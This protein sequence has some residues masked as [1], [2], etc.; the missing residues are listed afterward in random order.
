MTKKR[1]NTAALDYH[2]SYPPGKLEIRA[3]KPLATRHDLSLAYSPGVADACMAI[4]DNQDEASAVTA[5]SNLVAVISNGTAVLGLGNIG[6]LASKPVMEGKAVLFKHFGGINV[7]DIEVNETEVDKFCDVVAALE[8]TFGG[9]NLEDIKAPECFEIER[10]LK[11][12]LKIP[13]FHD[14]QHGTA[15]TASA[16]LINGL[17]LTNKTAETIRVVCNGAGAAGIACLDMFIS[18]GV[19][20]E[21]IV[22]CDSKGVVHAGRD[23]LNK[24]K[25]EFAVETT[26]RTLADAMAGSDVFLGVSGPGLVTQDMVK[27]MAEKPLIFAMANP[28]P[29]ILPEE[30]QAARS[31][32]ICATGRS[33]FANQINNVLCFP[34]LFRG[35]LDVGAQIIN[36]EM[37]IACAHAIANLARREIDDVVQQAYVGENLQFGENMILPKPFDQRLLVEVPT[38]VAEAAMKSGV[39]TKPIANLADYRHSLEGLIFRSTGVMQTIFNAA[40]AAPKKVVFA[41]A[42]NTKVLTAVQMALDEGF[43][44]PILIG[45]RRVLET[46]I[47]RLNLRILFGDNAELVDPEKDPRFREYHE[48]YYRLMYRKGV[49]P[50]QSKTMVRTNTNII[51]TLMLHRGECD[52]AI[53]GMSGSPAK[54]LRI[55]R[56]IIGTHSNA[57]HLIGVHGV[58]IND[59]PIFIADTVSIVQ[60]NA[61]ELVEIAASAQKV[62]RQFGL[63]PRIALVSHSNFGSSIQPSAR[64]VRAAVSMLHERYPDMIVDGEMQ[65][66]TALEIN[67]RR[68]LIQESLLGDSSANLL[69]MPNIDAASIAYRLL[70]SAS[71]GFTIGPILVGTAKPVH[72][73]NAVSSSRSIY[74]MIAYAVTEAQS[75]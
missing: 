74:N 63:D 25:R 6:A 64:V 65:A 31:D 35:A 10:K 38:A 8:P 5:R 1:N 16:A 21:N 60:P 2:R 32:A 24:Y 70:K 37:K 52:A 46:M 59:R 61:E 22:L 30:A 17:F 28:I 47:K 51:A 33:D 40:Y 53:C 42:E 57:N 73:M 3:T 15:I 13:V 18:I 9:I 34:F 66:D 11:E 48:L 12:R 69:V 23:D 58:L 7:F 41:D 4:V 39:A 27:S 75:L 56:N 49:T 72:L 14:D 44:Y 29:E 55:I 50:E 71:D 62:V 36:E 68:E 20:R 54:N 19:R 43:V 67:L 45:R 26:A